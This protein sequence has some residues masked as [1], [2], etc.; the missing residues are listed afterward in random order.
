MEPPL[1]LLFVIIISG[2][3]LQFALVK[4]TMELVGKQL[5][6]LFKVR[7]KTTHKFPTQTAS[8]K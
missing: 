7:K 3:Q 4:F 2:L 5:T 6:E 1:T 8:Q